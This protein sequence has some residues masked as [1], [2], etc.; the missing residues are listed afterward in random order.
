[1]VRKSFA[2]VDIAFGDGP[3]GIDV[4]LKADASFKMKILGATVFTGSI[5]ASHTVHEL[6]DADSMVGSN[7]VV[8]SQ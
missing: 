4:V 5:D 2:F 6:V 7:T 8:M 1:M 3:N